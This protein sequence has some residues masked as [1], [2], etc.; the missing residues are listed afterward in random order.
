MI[1]YF[2]F[3]LFM[4]VLLFASC[5]TIV[6]NPTERGVVFN[7]YK[8]LDTTNILGEGLNTYRLTEEVI[9]FDITEKLEEINVTCE[10]S[11]KSQIDIE[12]SVFYTLNQEKLPQLYQSYGKNYREY[13]LIPQLR[14]AVR[15]TLKYYRPSEL[16][17]DFIEN[18]LLKGI[19]EELKNKDFIKLRAFILRKIN[20]SDLVQRAIDIGLQ[21][22]LE[23]LKSSDAEKRMLAIKNLLANGSN[24]AIEI[25]LNHWTSERDENIRKLIITELSK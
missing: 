19:D 15:D 22:E 14:H 18:I 8:G 4:I 11:G 5:R 6:L 16:S 17:F 25:I 21:N 20:F 3:L 24:T 9:I 1:R 10:L 13:Y 7:K 12:F 2:S 23:N